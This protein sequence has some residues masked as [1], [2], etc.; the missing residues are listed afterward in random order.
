MLRDVLNRQWQTED[1]RQNIPL[2]FKLRSLLL[3]T[4]KASENNKQIDSP[5]RK[6]TNFDPQNNGLPIDLPF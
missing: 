1:E 4:K 5:I 2:K 6:N 3:S